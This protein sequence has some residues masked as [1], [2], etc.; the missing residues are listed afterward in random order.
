MNKEALGSGVGAAAVSLVS[1][2]VPTV[3]PTLQQ[4]IPLCSGGCAAAVCTAAWI[5]AAAWYHRY[6]KGEHGHE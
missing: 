6:K 2:A 3:V 4:T 1:T 5:G